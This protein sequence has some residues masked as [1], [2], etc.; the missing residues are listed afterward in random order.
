M[1]LSLEITFSAQLIP[2]YESTQVAMEMHAIIFL[3]ALA[4]V[5][6]KKIPGSQE[7]RDL[8]AS[9]W[10]NTTCRD[11]QTAVIKTCAYN[12]RYALKCA[13]GEAYNELYPGTIYS[14]QPTHFL[15]QRN[16]PPWRKV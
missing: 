6:F 9:T 14:P 10:V 16:A 3:K 2:N 5:K 1:R 12:N 13:F 7:F 8:T 11:I 15:Q 4:K